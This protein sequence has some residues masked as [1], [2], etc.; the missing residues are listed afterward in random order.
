[1]SDHVFILIKNKIEHKNYK[2]KAE[3]VDMINYY[4]SYKKLSHEHYKILIEM[5]K[6]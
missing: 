6:N 1:M 5:L 4:F 2:N 3:V